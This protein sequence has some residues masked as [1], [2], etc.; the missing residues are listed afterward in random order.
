M[1]PWIQVIF[2]VGVGIYTVFSRK[3][4]AVETH[5]FWGPKRAANTKG[6]E[7]AYAVAGVS[8]VAMGLY[9]AARLLWK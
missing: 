9:K 2:L 1:D 5:R 8:F 6:Y 3:G 7:M 4:S